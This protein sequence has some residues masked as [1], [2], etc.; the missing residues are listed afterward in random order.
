MRTTVG[1]IDIKMKNTQKSVAIIGAGMAGL[2]AAKTLLQA[3]HRVTLF[4]KSWGVGGRVATRT[5]EGSRFDHGAQ[6]IKPEGSELE[7]VMLQEL[8]VLELVEVPE[9][10]V[11]FNSQGA[12]LPVDPV[13]NAEKKYSYARGATTLPKLLISSFPEERFTLHL[14]S[15][16]ARFEECR[17]GV[18]LFDHE[19]RD[20]GKFDSVIITAPAPQTADLIESSLMQNETV[21][22]S[23]VSALRSIKYRPC[24]SVLLGYE[25]QLTVDPVYALI[26]EDRSNPL[27]WLA[28]EHLKSPFRSPNKTT[29]LI[30]QFGGEFS[31][32]SYSAPDSDILEATYESMQ[33]ILPFDCKSPL[34]AQV[35][36]WRYSQPNGTIAF[37][38][39]NPE[40]PRI[41]VAGDALRPGNGRVQ[42][43]FASGI[44]AGKVVM[45]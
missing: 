16:I 10:V 12:R 8:P 14:E 18:S 44:E 1:D 7:A 19:K 27:L 2:G 17:E 35:K 5:I 38:E 25:S 20:L 31:E 40:P 30:A 3:G 13:R 11:A 39:A 28:F 4:E 43:A 21:Q 41:V 37:S 34:F 33:D 42:E 24:L 32:A 36:K 22:N 6:I 45:G 29:L 15:R 26:A 23:Q 9:P